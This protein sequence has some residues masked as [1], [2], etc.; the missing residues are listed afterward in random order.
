MYILS[1][2]R[3]LV[4]SFTFVSSIVLVVATSLRFP[5]ANVVA[6]SIPLLD[7]KRCARCVFALC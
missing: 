7:S 5:A 6:V 2:V 4:R 1:F 3:S